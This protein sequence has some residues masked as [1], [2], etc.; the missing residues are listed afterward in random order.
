MNKDHLIA[1]AAIAGITVA[2]A[3]VL[4]CKMD[5]M[6]DPEPCGPCESDIYDVRG[7]SKG[8]RKRNKSTRW[9]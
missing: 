3:E 1:I 6:F 2:E 7:Q 8:E 5:A 4:D 9:C